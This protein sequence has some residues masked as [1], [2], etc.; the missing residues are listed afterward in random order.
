MLTAVEANQRTKEVRINLDKQVNIVLDMLSKYIL[1]AI[2]H[3]RYGTNFCG[4]EC[5]DSI[6]EQE[7]IKE[8]IQ[9][10]YEVKSFKMSATNGR[11]IYRISW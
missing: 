2:E 11:K 7:V 9:L 1:I 8:L 4:A 3:G 6:V 5:G 10:G